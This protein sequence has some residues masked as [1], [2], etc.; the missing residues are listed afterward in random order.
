[1]NNLFLIIFCTLSISGFAQR[2]VYYRHL[3]YNHVSPCIALLGVHPIDERTAEN[4]SHYI[5]KYDTQDRLKEIINKHYHTEK[6]HPLSSLGVYR[7]VF[8]YEKNREVRTFFDPNDRRIT[9]DRQVFKE[10]YL[11]N[12]KG[13]KIQLNFY[14]LDDQPMES[15]WEIAE[16]QWEKNAKG[17]IE[18]RYNLKGEE[19]NLSPYFEFG[20]TRIETDKNGVPKRQ[21]NLNEELE[22]IENKL[23]VASY[24]DQYDEKG[25]HVKYS[26]HDVNNDLV[27]NQWSFA[28]GEKVYDSIGN[29]VSL[30]LYDANGEL[31]RSRDKYSNAYLKLASAPTK[32][33]TV[34][35]EKVSLGYLIALQELK[36]QLMDSILNDSLNKITIGY[37][38][39]LGKQFG[40]ATVKTQMLDFATNWNKSGAKFPFR[41]QNE[42]IILDIYD[43]IATV[44]LISDNWVEYLQLIKLDGHW[45]IMN[46]IWQ[47]KD[48]RR[49]GN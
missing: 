1:M 27:L 28:V 17:I 21:Y 22:V 23:G 42:V 48:V 34:E 11:L 29:H 31:I 25:N 24:Q 9:N 3:M 16:Y 10:V 12:R 18:R 6:V 46:L 33:D 30:N 47:Y 14:G 45:E 7:V 43:R 8:S 41:P 2:S 4:T 44:K 26:Y 20:T 19:A 36:P 35:I 32:K 49:Y 37:D 38:R 40:R 15:N 5:F 39:K 13:D